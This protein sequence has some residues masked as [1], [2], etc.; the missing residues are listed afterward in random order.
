MEKFCYLGDTNLGAVNSFETR[1]RNA[2]CEFR[3][4]VSFLASRVLHLRA[5]SRLYS[6]FITSVMLYGC[7]TMPIKEENMARLE[8]SY[9]RIVRWMCYISPEDIISAERM[10]KVNEIKN[11]NGLVHTEP[12]RLVVV[13]L[14]GL[15]RKT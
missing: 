14:R 11:Y 2:W 5:K 7:E 6:A 1:I 8:K 12:S 9:L 15:L 4:L 10:I 3:V 13:S